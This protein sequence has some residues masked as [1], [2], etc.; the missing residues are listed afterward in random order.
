MF[1]RRLLLLA[2]IA[3]ATAE[4]ARGD[5]P[6][7][8]DRLT[9]PKQ[10][11]LELQR[12][13]IADLDGVQLQTLADVV[14]LRDQLEA[15]PYDH[16]GVLKWKFLD[17]LGLTVVRHEIPP[18]P[19]GVK[20]ELIQGPAWTTTIY[21]YN[22]ETFVDRTS[23]DTTEQTHA[24]SPVSEVSLHRNGDDQ[25]IVHSVPRPQ[26]AGDFIPEEVL[27]RSPR[28]LDH[29]YVLR[30]AGGK[31]FHVIDYPQFENWLWVDPK[32]DAIL[33]VAA[34]DK[35]N[36]RVI[37]CTLLL[38]LQQPSD[39]CRFPMPRLVLD[40]S[41]LTD[42]VCHVTMY[43]FNQV[44]FETPIKPEQLQ[45]PVKEGAFYNYKT[46]DVDFQRRLPFDVDDMLNLFPESVQKMIQNQ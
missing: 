13:I 7:L 40:F 17:P 1:G 20:I 42:D 45:V 22:K 4:V 23:F 43:H 29:P 19:P 18:S 8:R 30:E 25:T 41:M 14:K 33:A 24:R 16:Q 2:L 28:S 11:H 21:D 38:Y 9:V 37:S 31:S 26:L 39:Q 34:V 15:I 36:N 10:G 12:A 32:Q 46:A 3:F 35:K 27:G 44:D 6:K 5:E